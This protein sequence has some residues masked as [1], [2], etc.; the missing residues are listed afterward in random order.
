M[1]ASSST[2]PARIS[3]TIVLGKGLRFVECHAG[4]AVAATSPPVYRYEAALV[5][6]QDNGGR[7]VVITAGT[8]DLC[9]VMPDSVR[10]EFPDRC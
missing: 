10:R 4:W 8:G 7:W 5:I 9:S 3:R 6:F 1:A 2:S